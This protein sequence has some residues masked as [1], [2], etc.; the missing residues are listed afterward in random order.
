M[1]LV[2]KTNIFIGAVAAVLITANVSVLWFAIVPS[3]AQ[4]EKEGAEADIHRVVARIKAEGENLVKSGADWAV[5][6][7]SYAYLRGENESYAEDNFYL[8]AWQSLDV[9]FAYFVAATGDVVYSVAFSDLDAGK[10]TDL[11]F[12]P[13]DRLAETHP[14]MLSVAT[15]EAV[16]GII[17]T[18]LEPLLVAAHPVLRNDASGP[19]SGFIAF[20]RFMTRAR[21]DQF[22][23]EVN[24]D[25]D[26]V[27][28]SED[29]WIAF[30]G[31]TLDN[32]HQTLVEEAP[33]GT[34]RRGTAT[35]NGPSGAPALILESLSPR[36]ISELGRREFSA[37]IVAMVIVSALTLIAVAIGMNR[38][39]VRPL[40]NLAKS[41]RRIAKTGN[42][43]ERTNFKGSDELGT[44]SRSFDHMLGELESVRER[45]LEQSFYAGRADQTSAA[46]HNIRNALNPV[47]FT[48]WKVGQIIKES[49][50]ARVSKAVAALKDPQIDD[51]KRAKFVEYLDGV[52]SSLQTE[53]VEIQTL[54]DTIATQSREIEEI[55]NGLSTP[56]DMNQAIGP[57]DV[58]S[59][60]QDLESTATSRKGVTV[61][62]SVDGTVPSIEANRVILSQIMANLVTNARE[63]IEASG[64]SE[65]SIG[66]RCVATT[67]EDRRYA[68]ITIADDGEGFDQIARDRLFERGF[69]TRKL[70]AGGLGLHWC[71]NSIVAIGGS[72]DARSAGTGQ[73]ASFTVT[74]P[75]AETVEEVAA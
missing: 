8:E 36:Q 66:I 57:V 7:E 45:L 9:D 20:G 24:V 51:S 35:V 58:M 72:I 42:M 3:F 44:V 40:Q 26:A 34:V 5:W 29:R 33:T 59:V 1:R 6:D 53:R 2:R 13:P 65:G 70:K 12:A 67:G 4:L 63:A 47:G 16:V 43:A 27:P 11:S 56:L 60:I 32:V 21:L 50:A 49:S 15:S 55:L 71:A 14:L 68:E 74:F 69:S 10:E 38:L 39:V 23:E 28:Y 64:K 41:M 62:F 19:P 48:A 31:A 30:P 22:R 61:A 52:G 54:V 25:F 75:I 73:G 46:M 18:E 17:Q 37:S